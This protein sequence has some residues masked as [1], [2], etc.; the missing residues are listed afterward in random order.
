MLMSLRQA[1]HTTGL[2]RTA[3]LKAIKRGAH[4]AL[5]HKTAG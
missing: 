1:G 2:S 3:I 5:P 4:S